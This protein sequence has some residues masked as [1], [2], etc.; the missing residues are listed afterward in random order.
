MSKPNLA[1]KWHDATIA[2]QLLRTDPKLRQLSKQ[3]LRAQSRLQRELS[4]EGWN[5]YLRLEELMDTRYS[6]LLDRIRAQRGE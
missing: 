1:S 2:D 4:A 5:L 3:I 6:E